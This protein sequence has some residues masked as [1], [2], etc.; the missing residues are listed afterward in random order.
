MWK[1]ALLSACAIGEGNMHM[2][3]A[4]PRTPPPAHVHSP[5]FHHPRSAF[6]IS[7][8]T[9]MEL[10]D[11]LKEFMRCYPRLLQIAAQIE[12]SICV[13]ADLLTNRN[14][15]NN[16]VDYVSETADHS[17]ASSLTPATY[18]SPPAGL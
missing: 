17:S 13:V 8:N 7:P 3:S 11:T 9:E 2:Y 4:I 15:D 6:V 12:N 16:H 10:S 1:R 14:R 5:T 18:L